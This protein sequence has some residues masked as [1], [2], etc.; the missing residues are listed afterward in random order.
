[1]WW[2]RKLPQ[3]SLHTVYVIPDTEK[4]REGPIFVMANA[5]VGVPHSFP[6]AA[7]IAVFRALKLVIVGLIAGE[8][9]G[10]AMCTIPLSPYN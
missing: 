4:E 1:M 9:Y 10:T 8:K 6:L 2:L 3:P 7:N 5:G